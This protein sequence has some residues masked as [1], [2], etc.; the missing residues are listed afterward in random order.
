MI[1][2][3]AFIRNLHKSQSTRYEINKWNKIERGSN[4]CLF[5][6]GGTQKL[7]VLCM[8]PNFNAAIWEQNDGGC[9]INF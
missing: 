9:L 1:N 4:D 2:W 5:P 7:L 3:A 6:H 8:C